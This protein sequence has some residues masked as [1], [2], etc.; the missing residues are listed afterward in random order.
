MND[1]A[2]MDKLI[3]SAMAL[4]AERGWQAT[5]YTD[6]LQAA[7]LVYRDAY[8]VA[9][10]KQ[11]VMRGFADRMDASMLQ[12]AEAYNPQTPVR[13]LLF[14][15][16]MA[17]FDALTD[18]K[19]AMARLVDEQQRAPLDAIGTLLRLDRSMALVLEAAGETST[20]FAGQLR[21]KALMALYVRCLRAW[22]KDESEDLGPTMKTL[23]ES[24]AQAERA[25]DFLA[26]GP[27][28]FRWPSRDAEAETAPSDQDEAA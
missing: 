2:T 11:D 1:T 9:R 19:S 18:Y 3:D 13:E 12:D 5:S 7:G 24:L 25:A 6:I 10:D 14:D 16:I 28:A 8:K 4:V 27:R 23:D 21:V 26:K 22:L 17:R 20:G 15:L